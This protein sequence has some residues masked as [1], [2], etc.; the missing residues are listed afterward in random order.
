MC[1]LSLPRVLFRFA[2]LLI[3]QCC[4]LV[5]L[6]DIPCVC[7]LYHL[8]WQSRLSV[9]TTW[10]DSPMCLLSL[11]PDMTVPCACCLYHLTWQPHLSV[12]FTTWHDSPICLLSPL[13]MTV[14]CVCCLYHLTWQSHVSAVFTT[15][16]DSPIC[17]YHHLTWKKKKN[18]YIY[19][20]TCHSVSFCSLSV[21]LF[22]SVSLLVWSYKKNICV[23][24]SHCAPYLSFSSVPCLS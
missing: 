12:V 9:T 3:W 8:T 22:C 13:D 4:L 11:P 23:K 2:S 15:W 10:Y 1:L 18:I 14:P 7:C 20:Y 24:V 17:C 6:V 16:H 19:I 5:L 21:F